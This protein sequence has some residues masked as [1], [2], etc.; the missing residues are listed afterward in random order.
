MEEDQGNAGNSSQEESGSQSVPAMRLCGT[1][2]RRQHST[3]PLRIGGPTFIHCCR[4]RKP[5]CSGTNTRM[6]VS[7]AVKLTCTANQTALC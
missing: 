1:R 7:T 6:R 2:P 4:A 3:A 5:P